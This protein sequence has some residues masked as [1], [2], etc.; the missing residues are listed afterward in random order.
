V[1]LSEVRRALPDMAKRGY[2]RV[3]NVAS[4]HGLSNMRPWAPRRGRGDHQLHL[5]GLDRDCDHRT[6]DFGAGGRVRQ[7]P[8]DAVISSLLAEKHPSRR[9]SRPEEIGSLALCLAPPTAHK[10]ARISARVAVGAIE[11]GRKRRRPT[12]NSL[13]SSHSLL[14][15]HQSSRTRLPEGKQI[16]ARVVFMGAPLAT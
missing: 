4:V 1:N 14:E 7:R 15:V 3:I 13:W 11:R 2:G 16:R 5:P 10:G 8:R 6:A 12:F 9:T